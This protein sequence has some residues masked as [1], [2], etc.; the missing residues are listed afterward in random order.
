[1]SRPTRLQALLDRLRHE[2]SRVAA[3][4]RDLA[5]GRSRHV[6][7]AFARH[8]EQGL[9]LRRQAAVREGHL[10]LVLEIAV[11]ANAADDDLRS[12][13]PAEIDEQSVGIVVASLHD[14]V[15]LQLSLC[16]LPTYRIC[17]CVVRT[18]AVH[19]FGTGITDDQSAGF[20]FCH[21]RNPVHD[22]TM[23]GK[24][25]RETHL[26]TVSI[27]YCFYL[28]TY[29]MFH[30]TRFDQFHTGR[31]HLIT[32]FGSL[33]QF[34]YFLRFLCGAHLHHSH[35][36]FYRSCILLLVGMNTQQVEN[37]YFGVKAVRRQEVDLSFLSHSLVAYRFQILHGNRTAYSGLCC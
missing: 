28:S 35:D 36:Q 1:M 15:Y 8:H 30:D 13:P 19:C 16:K 32:Y 17:T 26:R 34:C 4:A 11:D 10:E 23:L 29:I 14:T 5:D 20:Q 18:I 7:K 9:D 22:L 31:M 33:F 12:L 2:R 3:V 25:G 37:L 6:S 21:R 27:G 24:D